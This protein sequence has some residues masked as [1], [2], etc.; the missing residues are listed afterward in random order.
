[1]RRTNEI[2]E[3]STI[4]VSYDTISE[5]WHRHFLN[6]HHKL[7]SIIPESIEAIRIKETSTAVL[8]IWFDDVKSLIE[9]YNIQLQNI[10]NMDETG[11]SIGSIKATR[12]IIAKTR[13]SQYSAE[14]RTAV[15]R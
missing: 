9:I 11:F 3:P 8:Q 2:N 15:S 4:Y 6:H 10:Y 5:Q 14:P 7:E 13:L 1:M 12:V